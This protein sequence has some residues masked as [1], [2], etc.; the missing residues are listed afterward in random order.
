M[1]LYKNL[2]HRKKSSRR[3]AALNLAREEKGEAIPDNTAQNSYP[4]F[5]R[6][7]LLR[8]SVRIRGPN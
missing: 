1:T 2:F 6:E 7:L 8:P 5:C 3:R 4:S